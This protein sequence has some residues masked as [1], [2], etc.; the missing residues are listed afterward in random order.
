MTSDD[1]Y[2]KTMNLLEK[3]NY[4]G[5]GKHRIDIVKQENV[6]ALINNDAKIAIDQ[7]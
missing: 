7:D 1:T 3:N 4:F 2:D 5:L 6:P